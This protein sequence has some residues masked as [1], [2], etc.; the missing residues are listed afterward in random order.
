M[1]APPRLYAHRGAAVEL[2]ENTMAAFVRALEYGVDA[3]EMDVHVTADGHVVVSHDPSGKRMCGID[4]HIRDH[5]LED[6][7]SWDAGR[8]FTSEDGS[9]PFAGDGYCIPTF[10]QVLTELGDVIINADLKQTRPSM[11][12]AFVALVRRHKA[13]DRVIAASFDL[14]TTMAIRRAGYEGQT[15]LPRAEVLA[16]LAMPRALFQRL[17]WRGHAVQIPPRVGPLDLASP[18][19]IA[20]CHALDLRVDYW[21]INDPAEARRLLE[22]GADGIM[23]DDPARLVP[24]FRQWRDEQAAAAARR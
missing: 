16:L 21:T 1:N 23:T 9:R 11:V 6:V 10:E 17:P 19:F 3:L 12:D 5:T 14:R 13:C 18:S 24:V 4:A 15:A 20:K 2:P 22:A 8:N 7:Q